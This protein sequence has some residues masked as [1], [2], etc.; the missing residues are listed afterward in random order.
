VAYDSLTGQAN[1]LASVE[2]A[3]AERASAERASAEQA[4]AEQAS[5]SLLDQV[6]DAL[7]HIY[8]LSYLQDHS[9]A[10]RDSQPSE[11][12]GQRLRRNLSAAIEALNPG[13]A[14]PFLS[15][16]ARLFNLLTLH[17]LEG[18]T[19]QEAAYKLGISRRQATRDL[20]RAIENVAASLSARRPAAP[21]LSKG[22]AHLSSVHE[23]ISRL[24]SRSARISLQTLICSAQNTVSSLAAQRGV[25]LQIMLPSQPLLISTDQMIAEQVFVNVLSQT[26]GRASQGPIELK[27]DADGGQVAVTVSFYREPEAGGKQVIGLVVTQ[28]VDR[29]GWAIEQIDTQEGHSTIV[30]RFSTSG[31]TVLVIDDNQG[32]VE[33]LDRYLTDQSLTVISAK[34][35][36][37][38]ID[39]AEEMAPDAIILDVMMPGMHGWEV[40]QRLRMLSRTASIPV[41]ICSVI[42]DPDLA[43]SLGASQVL[44]KPISRSAV[45]EVLRE[46][47]IV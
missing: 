37:H 13:S 21:S 24:G 19:V 38:G 36:Q 12:A 40:L 14:V 33:L 47:G 2:Q 43:Y 10:H 29:L 39:L 11:L 30:I 27:A 4:S 15:S 28:L 25:T 34:D 8:D 41:V 17:Y 35:G 3:S 18:M 1:A 9:L 32:L 5:A 44:P 23:E 7:E 26:I 20:R 22:T 16:Q 6:R 46:L 42:N 31:S 45:L